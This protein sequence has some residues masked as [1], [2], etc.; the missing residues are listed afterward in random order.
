MTFY[1]LTE[2]DDWKK[3]NKNGKGW[4]IKYYKGLGTSTSKEAKEYFKNMKKVQYT[5]EEQNSNEWID[6]AFNKKRADD[7]KD[8]LQTYDKNTILDSNDKNVS[9]NDFIEK[10]F[11]HFS[12]YDLERSIP[13]ICDGMKPS[14]RKVM[15][16][17]FKRN[18]KK[19]IKVAQLSQDMLVNIQLIIMAKL[20]Y[21]EQLLNWHKLMLEVIILII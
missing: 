12:N 7:R 3:A 21:K 9:F 4:H 16:S 6:L 13:S 19:E 5:W 1:T 11:K 2:Y 20:V 14:Q 10:E 17:C 15:Y 8:W 18:L